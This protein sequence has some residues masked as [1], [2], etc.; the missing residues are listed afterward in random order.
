MG[1]VI[2]V[3]G[4]ARPHFSFLIGKDRGWGVGKFAPELCIHIIVRMCNWSE[5]KNIFIALIH[6]EKNDKYC[7]KYQ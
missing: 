4:W 5:C 3:A 7:F 6:S 2:T 1:P